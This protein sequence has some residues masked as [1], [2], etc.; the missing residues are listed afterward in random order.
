M[1]VKTPVVVIG[2]GEIGGVFAR[3]LLRAGYPIYPVTR[4]VEMEALARELPQPAAVLVAVGEGD[5]HGV[6]ETVPEAWRPGLALLQNELL[7]QDWKRHGLEQPTVISVWFEKKKGQDVKEIMPSP[8]FG[9]AAAMLCE[10]LGAVGLRCHTLSDAQALLQ[11]LVLK[12]LYILTTNIAGLEVGG[13]VG[14]L[15]L[16]HE[17]LTRA[18]AEEVLQIQEWQTGTHFDREALIAAMLD[19]FRADP[20][21]KCMGRS[22]PARL[23]RALGVAN[24]AGLDAPTL[25]RIAAATF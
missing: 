24:E 13:A 19:A 6:L 15:W 21:H 18:V 23:Q 11:E 5:L 25:R 1:P 10:A 8:A 2:L 14:E 4:D 7:P 22:A 9:P 17:A 3:G 16:R 20:E 12:N